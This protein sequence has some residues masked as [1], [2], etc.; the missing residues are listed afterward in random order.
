[1][2][3]KKIALVIPYFGKLPSYIDIFFKSLEFNKQIDVILFTDQDCNYDLPNLIVYKTSFEKIKAKIQ[4]KFPFEICLNKPY[5]LC[6]YRPSFGYVFDEEL[7]DYEFWGY[8]DLD[9]VLG[10]IMYFLNDDLTIFVR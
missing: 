10:D 2:K 6:D 7:K 9:E 1:M 5:K 8:C 4:N 3:K